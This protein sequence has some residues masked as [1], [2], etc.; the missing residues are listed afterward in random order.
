M[1]GMLETWNAL[2][3]TKR[4]TLVGAVI[5]T[6]LTVLALAQTATAPSMALLYGG[7]EEQSA[8]EVVTALDKMNVPYEIRGNAIYVDGTQRDFVRMSLARD[9]LPQ[10]GQKG[11]ELLDDLSGFGTTSEMFEAAYWRAKEGELGR[12]IMSVPGV[13][14]VRVHIGNASRRP[15]QQGAAKTTAAVT[16]R[17]NGGALSE[18][19]ALS[20]R[21]LVALS[22][23]GIDP[24]QVA[25]IDAKHGVV[26]RPGQDR[27]FGVGNALAEEKAKRLEQDIAT[28]LGVRV[29]DG[30][31]RVSVTVETTTEQETISERIV[32]P[33]SRV[34]LTADTSSLNE[35]TKGSRGVV[36]VA[37]NLPDGDAANGDGGDE[38]QRQESREQVTYSYS[39]TRR[40]QV[41]S[42]GAVKRI[43]VAVLIDEQEIISPDGTI[44]Y[45]A[46]PP[47]ELAAIQKLVQSAIAFDEGR[48]DVVTVE[49]MRFAA[50]PN[51]GEVVTAGFAERFLENNAM[52]LIQ[53]GILSVVA[54]LLGLLVV[55][56]ILSA[57]K[58]PM[59]REDELAQALPTS[60]TAGLPAPDG[61]KATNEMSMAE[62]A[63][64]PAETVVIE[65]K[66]DEGEGL[67]KI[68]AMESLRALVTEEQEASGHILK[69]WLNDTRTAVPA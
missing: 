54:L 43:G 4:L 30:N 41:K 49:S 44:T 34:T 63:A 17:T 64:E 13:S 16:V 57:T 27:A 8:G 37:S 5:G 12:T 59:L 1:A 65:D 62:L 29:G 69:N 66:S 61:A 58:A 51:T 56:P 19:S 55:K 35:Q 11:Y 24:K 36:T 40:D 67:E 42:A 20:I 45:Q 53:L 28:L 3:L 60:A 2:S 48:G 26:L 46:R 10:Q 33:E 6:I 7:L 38:S 47:E 23:A 14:S 50:I 22:V 25:V 9:G 15:F 68:G 39:E 21:Y 32:D 18:Q 52:S 31:V